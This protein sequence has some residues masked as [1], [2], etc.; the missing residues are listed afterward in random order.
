VLDLVGYGAGSAPDVT[1]D[2]EELDGGL[3][4]EPIG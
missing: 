4:A 1:A 3:L 2:H